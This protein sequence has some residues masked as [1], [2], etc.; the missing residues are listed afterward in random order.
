VAFVHSSLNV[1]ASAMTAL[2]AIPISGPLINVRWLLGPF[3][4]L[5][6]R[7]STIAQRPVP[8]SRLHTSARAL[9]SYGTAR[10]PWEPAGQPAVE[11][12]GYHNVFCLVRLVCSRRLGRC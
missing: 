4:F 8:K 5:R 12:R 7:I 2:D 6:H 9:I 3:C 11:A 10:A 1:I